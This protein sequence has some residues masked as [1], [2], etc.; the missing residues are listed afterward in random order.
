LKEIF[1][2]N[3]SNCTSRTDYFLMIWNEMKKDNV[4]DN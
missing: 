4:K 1:I 2:I 3:S